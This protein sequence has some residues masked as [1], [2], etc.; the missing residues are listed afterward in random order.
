MKTALTL[1]LLALCSTDVLAVPP[2]ETLKAPSDGF[3]PQVEVD[4]KGT[5]HIVQGS[6]T[7]RGDLFYLTRNPETGA[8][9]KPIRVNQIEGITASF[10]MTLGK[11]GRVHVLIRPN[12]KYLKLMMPEKDKLKFFD[13]KYML[14]TRL[15][16]EGT[17]FEDLRDLSADCIGF[18]GIGSV[19]AGDNGVVHAFFHGQKVAKMN[20]ESRQIFRVTSKDEGETFTD[21]VPIKTDAVGAC[22]CCPMAGILAK[23]GSIVLAYRGAT[24]KAESSKK[25]S[26]LLVSKD[27]GQSFTT[28]GIEGWDMAGC[29][30]SIYSLGEGDDGVFVG[31]RTHGTVKFANA[32]DVKKP[33]TTAVHGSTRCPIVVPNNSGQVLFVWNEKP[34][35][36]KQGASHVAWQLF[37]KSGKSL[38]EKKLLRRAGASR[39]GHPAAWANADGSFTVLFDGIGHGH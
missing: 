24:G 31:W 10:D 8:F 27:D 14:Y 7:S 2:V 4:A 1:I 37:D 15:N 17:A 32:N 29:P 22:Q 36:L 6:S 20:E 28:T 3:R 23:D 9:S 19:V 13:L 34:K 38:T 12:P 5:I 16:D 11:E 18:E 26:M 39:F 33:F 21:P 35:Y 25:E 30:G